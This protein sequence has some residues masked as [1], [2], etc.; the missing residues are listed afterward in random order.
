MLSALLQGP[1][2]S[3]QLGRAAG[4][5]NPPDVVLKLRRRVGLV[6]PV[7]FSTVRDRDGRS[8]ERGVY[9]LTTPDRDKAEAFLLA[10]LNGKAGT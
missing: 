5:N 2:T 9:A 8:V 7:T 4:S 1:K 6:I 3:Q 10:L